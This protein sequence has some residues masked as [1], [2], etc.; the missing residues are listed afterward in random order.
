MRED[1]IQSLLR[2]AFVC[3][4]LENHKCSCSKNIQE[5]LQN[6]EISKK[7][8]KSQKKGWTI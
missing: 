2:H 5:F 4:C 7:W 3:S 8:A 6:D 1:K